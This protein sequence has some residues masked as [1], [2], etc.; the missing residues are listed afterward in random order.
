M[1]VSGASVVAVI[2]ILLAGMF[3]NSG[4]AY[5]QNRG[6]DAL[7]VFDV[8]I[9]TSEEPKFALYAGFL[10]IVALGYSNVDGTLVG[11]GHRNVGV[12]PVRQHAAGIL[13]YGDEQFG[14]KDF[15]AA[16][17]NS[18][19]P[20]RVGIIGLM[21]GPGPTNGQVVNCPKLLHLGWI[22]LT[23]NCKF[24]ELADLALGLATIDIMNDDT[25]S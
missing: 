13:V 23:L 16:D 12:M 1:K 20:W 25:A 9:T 22:G 14:Y 15:N 17:P 7:D 8:G 2:I 3:F 24:G 19:E 11:I 18:P 21:E 6:N 5:L 10:N 4:C